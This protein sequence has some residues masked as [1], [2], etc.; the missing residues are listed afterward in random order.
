VASRWR[1]G[2]WHRAEPLPLAAVSR[3]LGWGHCRRASSWMGSVE[4]LPLASDYRAAARTG[5]AGAVQVADDGDEL[6]PTV[7]PLRK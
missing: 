6:G 3:P 1:P 4:R 5:G 2:H 7:A